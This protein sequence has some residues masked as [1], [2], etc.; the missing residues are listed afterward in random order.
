MLVRSSP[1]SRVLREARRRA[2]ASGAY[3]SS[4]ITFCNRSA[5]S[6]D[7]GALWLMYRLTVAT[8]TPAS[9]ATSRIVT[10]D[11]LRVICEEWGKCVTGYCNRLHYFTLT[12]HSQPTDSL[13]ESE[14]VLILL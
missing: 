13:K 5:T 2:A 11:C 1:T 6:S 14:E 10:E 8:E 9:L 12:T 7:T 4:L 3:R